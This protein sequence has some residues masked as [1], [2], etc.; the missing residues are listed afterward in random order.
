MIR[1]V[2]D[3]NVVVSANLID[4][5]ATSLSFGFGC[6]QENPNGRLRTRFGRIRRGA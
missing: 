2:I 3:T 5:G 4:E 6:Q 1:V